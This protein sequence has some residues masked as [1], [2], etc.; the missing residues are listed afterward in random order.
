MD[1]VYCLYRAQK[2]PFSS[3][4]LAPVSILRTF[5]LCTA[6]MLMFLVWGVKVM[7]VLYV[8]LKMTTCFLLLFK[9]SNYPLKVHEK[10]ELDSCLPRFKESSKRS[11]EVQ[12][13]CSA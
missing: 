8:M 11:K 4:N 2:H 9:G 13:F 5:T 10:S 1:W 7:C 12:T 3:S 6:L